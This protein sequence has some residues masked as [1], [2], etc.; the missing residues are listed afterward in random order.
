MKKYLFAVLLAVGSL[1]ANAAEMSVAD[2][3]K[4]S[5]YACHGFGA[6]GAPKT[7]SAEDWAPRLEKGMDTLVKHAAE[8]FG[9]MPPKG[10]CFDCS[11]ED[12]KALIEFMAEAK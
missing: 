12:F 8:G 9:T 5:C 2:R 3:Y 6:N 7:G 1:V 11:N 10:L 4:K